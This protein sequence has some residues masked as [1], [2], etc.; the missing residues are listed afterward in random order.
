VLFDD[1]LASY[2]SDTDYT[3]MAEEGLEVRLAGSSC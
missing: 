1:E 2:I 3:E